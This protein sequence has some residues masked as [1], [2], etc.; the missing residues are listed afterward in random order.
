MKR[1]LLC[2]ALL[3]GVIAQAPCGDD[4]PAPAACGKCCAA[5]ACPAAGAAPK[6]CAVTVCP[7]TTGAE[8][9]VDV[10]ALFPEFT[11]CAGAN[12]P[13]AGC[14][15]CCAAAAAAPKSCAAQPA[16]AACCE[17]KAKDVAATGGEGTCG[18]ACCCAAK[19][20]DGELYAE[21][22][23]ILKETESPDTFMAA[24]TG[25]MA[26]EGHGKR[27]IP[28]V[29]RSA[30]RLG[31]LNGIAKQLDATPAQALLQDYF[32][33]CIGRRNHVTPDVTGTPRYY[34]WH[35]PYQPAVVGM[36]EGVS[37]PYPGMIY[38]PAQPP[39]PPDVL[40]AIPVRPVDCAPPKKE[41][42]ESETEVREVKPKEKQ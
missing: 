28:A 8:F 7:A 15:T 20:G 16:G 18:A 13:A 34:T 35:T 3:A 11:G 9:L 19:G 17:A 41:V 1:W 22:V 4:A 5:K 25:L 30:E 26:T 23:A 6:G 38:G 10:F 37:A 21:L 40:R 33:T 32:E 2:L 36:P 42:P 27:A 12:K 31:L 24:V 14:G 39:M 29:I